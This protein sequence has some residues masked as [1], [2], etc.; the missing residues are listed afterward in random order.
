[1]Q[2]DTFAASTQSFS[3]WVGSGVTE[4]R[5]EADIAQIAFGEAAIGLADIFHQDLATIGRSNGD[6]E[7]PT[8]SQLVEQ[9]LGDSAGRCGHEDGIVRGG[10]WPTLGPVANMNMDSAKA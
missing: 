10:V 3:C 1:M 6:D 9:G 4:K 8:R 5:N 7:P 2:I